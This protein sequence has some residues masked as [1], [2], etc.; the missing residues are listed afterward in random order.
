MSRPP[1]LRHAF[2]LVEL[3]VVIAIIGVLVALLLPAVQAARESG[4]RVQCANN[5]KQ[6]GLAMH[7][8]HN[9]DRRFPLPSGG[10]W[11]LA[12]WGYPAVGAPSWM[13]R[14]LPYLEQSSVL[15]DSEYADPALQN[16]PTFRC[17]SDPQSGQLICDAN[18][19]AV[20]NY[21]GVTG[22]DFSFGNTPTNG[23][24]DLSLQPVTLASVLDGTS[25]TLM[26]GER[27]PNIH[28]GLHGHWYLFDSMLSTNQVLLVPAGC[29]IPAT[30]AEGSIKNPCDSYHF[31][32]PHPGGGL[33]CLADASVRQIAYSAGTLTIPLSTRAGGETV[34]L[35]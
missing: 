26:I 31:W 2:T 35:P 4:R 11:S 10:L 7:M 25:H 30:Y 12:P 32:G 15:D 19:C 16:I 23:I 8:Y 34:A 29:P 21:V 28:G 9:T 14:L 22:S 3:L 6:L 5:L 1:G 20:T 24:F 13:Y 17:P 18:W 27:P 33:W